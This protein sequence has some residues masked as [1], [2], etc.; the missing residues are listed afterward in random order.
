MNQ[1][2]DYSRI[3]SEVYEQSIG[4]LQVAMVR[5]E[6][7]A[8]T[9]VQAYLARIAALD[10]GGPGLG[11]VLELNPE[12]EAYAAALDAERAAGHVRGPLHGIPIL[13]KDNLDTA[14]QTHTTAGSLALLGSRPRAD[15]T[16]VR[17]LREAGAI[18]LGKTNLSEW[19]NFRSNRSTSGWSARGG[20]THNPY[21]LERNPCGSSSGS[22]AA[23]A[24][25]LCA[26]AVGTETDGSIVCPSSL[27]GVVGIKPTVGLTSRVG[28]I[29]ISTTQDTVGP[30][31]RSVTDA[32]LLLAV[33]AGPD[34]HDPAGA[35]VAAADYLGALQPGA[36]RGARLGVVRDAGLVGY[37]RHTDAVFEQNL[38]LLRD[39]GAILIDPLSLGAD[40]SEL[41]RAEFTVLLYE[42]KAG[43]EAYLATREPLPGWAGPLAPRTMAELIA[44]NEAHAKRELR[45]FGQELLVKSAATSGLSAPAYQEALALSRDTTRQRFD[46]L[47]ANYRL[48]AIVAP[49]AQ[50]AW[51]TDLLNGDR[52]AG[53]SS[54]P[55]ARAG[56]PIVTVPSGMV[57][58]LPLGLSL[59][60]RAFSEA[61]LIGLAF[62]FEQAANARRAPRLLPHTELEPPTS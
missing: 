34:P 32:A 1:L 44:F 10:Q 42:F 12:A 51:I 37:N 15:A 35:S 18:L 36:L 56:Y 6:L 7:H 5:G 62:A 40:E 52:Y 33:L 17:R 38:T 43:L 29:P 50:P 19:A 55:S 25:S 41:G 8:L 53:S 24:A 11:A 22:A 4:A 28:V 60:G 16:V 54:G 9:L 46:E 61:R 14:D 48:D 23:T 59:L 31:A 30:H 27:C 57:A 58:G 45:Y 26:A 47:F 49:T 13:L 3:G 39:E 21:V 2:P 20:Q